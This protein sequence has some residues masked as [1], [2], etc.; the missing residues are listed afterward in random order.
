MQK[1]S[2]KKKV[3]IMALEISTKEF[4]SAFHSEKETVFIRRFHDKDKENNP[5]ENMAIPFSKFENII[6]TLEKFNQND[7]GIFFVVNGG[8]QSNKDVKQAKAQFMEIDHFSI[9]E[10]M[11]A[12]SSF[13]LPP[14]LIVRT[15]KSLHTYWLLDNGDIKKFRNIQ[16]RLIQYFGSDNLIKNESRV[17]RLPGFYHNKSD[18]FMVEIIKFDKEL[19]YTQEQLAEH[20][21]EVKVEKPK[22]KKATHESAITLLEGERNAKLTSRAGY[23]HKQGISNPAILQELLFLNNT[24]CNPPLTENEVTQIYESVVNRYEKGTPTI[25]KEDAIINN[26]NLRFHK[27]TKDRIPCEII[28]NEI[29]NFILETVDFF[30]LGSEPYLYDNGVYSRDADGNRLKRM[31]QDCIENNLV[32]ANRINRVYSL[33]LMQ[34][35]HKSY[36]ELNKYPNYFI[37]FKNGL[38][39]VIN[40]VMYENHPK[41]FCINQIPHYYNPDD[42]PM[43]QTVE[44]FLSSALNCEE[45]KKTIYQYLGLC[46]TTDNSL[47]KFICLRG[48]RGTGK[49]VLIKLFQNIIGKS[50]ISNIPLQDIEEKFHK[51]QMLGKT[52]NCCADIPSTPLRTVNT[53]KLITGGDTISDSFKGKDIVTFTPY[54]KLLFSANEIP[55]SLDEKSNA[56]FKRLII[57]SMNNPPEQVDRSLN[58][59]LEKDV[60]YIIHRAV[61]GLSEF[62]HNNS[63]TE[64]ESST[65]LVQALYNASD[66]VSGFIDEELTK[67]IDSKINTTRLHEEYLQYC[68]KN[69]RTPLTIQNFYRNLEG[70][71]YAK[72]KTN[73]VFY[74]KGLALKQNDF[75]PAP[76]NFNVFTKF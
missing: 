46:M 55:I 43:Q 58:A 61:E 22:Q 42:T 11:H 5:A 45:D 18:P 26:P 21:P 8:S 47:Q 66:S 53:I 41:Y 69:E 2:F 52:L 75:A 19:R 17:M 6:P 59:K 7:Y 36:E 3:F 4:L 74:F 33:I 40:K 76:N 12:I 10:Q 37:P 62:Y 63:I 54:C 72:C 1:N 24:S 60:S 30:I 9:E 14:S 71:G 73:G 50:N 29:C 23:L 20:L 44:N 51:I 67:D 34:D 31:I 32:T 16:E 35:K 56:F 48:S 39:D 28:E 68:E 49:S 65:K 70:K 38:Y 25:T 15:R 64:S 57:I 13:P 27:L